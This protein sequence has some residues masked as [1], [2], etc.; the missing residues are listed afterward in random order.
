[1]RMRVGGCDRQRQQKR[2]INI[3]AVSSDHG[4]FNHGSLEAGVG[5]KHNPAACSRKF[6]RGGSD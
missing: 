3:G 1:M 2:G 6:H 4:M 5:L